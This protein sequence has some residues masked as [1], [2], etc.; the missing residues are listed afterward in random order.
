[1]NTR[2]SRE[3]DFIASDTFPVLPLINLATGNNVGLNSPNLPNV[4]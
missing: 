2:S 3:T 1:M 4:L